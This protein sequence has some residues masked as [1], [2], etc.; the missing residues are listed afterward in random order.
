[1]F[2]KTNE[3]SLKEAIN[4]LLETYKLKDKYNE[5]NIVQSWADIMGPMVA[6]RTSELFIRNRKLFVRLDSAALRHELTRAK[7][8]IVEVVN[9]KSGT[10]LID[11]VVFL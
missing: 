5:V 11:D 1:M 2:K 8:K 6:N 7:D 4:L 9:D 3:Q 10:R